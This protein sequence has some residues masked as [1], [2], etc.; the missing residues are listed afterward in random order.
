MHWHRHIGANGATAPLE[1]AEVEFSKCPNPLSFHFFVNGEGGVRSSQCIMNIRIFLIFT[2]Q[3][4]LQCR[5][6]FCPKLTISYMYYV[7]KSSESFSSSYTCCTC[8]QIHSAKQTYFLPAVGQRSA[9]NTPHSRVIPAAQHRMQECVGRGNWSREGRL[10]H[11]SI[12]TYIMGN[13]KQVVNYRRAARSGSRQVAS[14]PLDIVSYTK[15]DGAKDVIYTMVLVVPADQTVYSEA[16]S[17]SQ[18]ELHKHYKSF[19]RKLSP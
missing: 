13:T 3:A 5:Q 2:V 10:V 4:S 14:R 19:S 17:C 7:Y 15:P 9:S 1:I 16:R 12:V 6:L 8:K 18:T 11:S